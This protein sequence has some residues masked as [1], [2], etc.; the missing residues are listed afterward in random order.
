MASLAACLNVLFPN[1]LKQCYNCVFMRLVLHLEKRS[2]GT[3][4]LLLGV[5]LFIRGSKLLKIA[6]KICF[7]ID[8]VIIIVF[9][10]HSLCVSSITVELI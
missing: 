7:I 1:P 3:L 4:R 9:H 2:V 8:M 6:F 10:K 5:D